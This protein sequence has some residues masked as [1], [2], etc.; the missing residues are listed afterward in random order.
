M[1][2]NGTYF[3]KMLGCEVMIYPSDHIT[4][5]EGCCICGKGKDNKLICMVKV[6][7]P[8]ALEY[9]IGSSCIEKIGLVKGEQK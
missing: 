6:D 2:Y 8:D 1:K 9:Y 7:D 3:S 4:R 5:D